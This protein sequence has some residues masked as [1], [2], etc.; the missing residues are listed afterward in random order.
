MP[1]AEYLH[2]DDEPVATVSGIGTTYAVRYA[3]RHDSGHLVYVVTV[4]SGPVTRTLLATPDATAA[5]WR[6]A[7]QLV[8]RVCRRRAD[9]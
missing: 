3:Q 4:S 9:R 2:I 7:M 6:R 8:T 1:N 5:D